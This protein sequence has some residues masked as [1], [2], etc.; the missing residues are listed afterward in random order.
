MNVRSTSSRVLALS[1]CAFTACATW[2]AQSGPPA[3]TLATPRDQVR[4]TLSDG[5]S[6]LVN[7]ARVEGDSVV[8]IA[9]RSSMAGQTSKEVSFPVTEV[10]RVEFSDINAGQTVGLVAGGAA[11]LFVVMGVMLAED[12]E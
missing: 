7:S 2:K 3:E 10:R 8:G 12:L 4:L 1:L 6:H 9:P 5:S 11:L